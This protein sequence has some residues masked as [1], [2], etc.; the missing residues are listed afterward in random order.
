VLRS[1]LLSAQLA[2]T[3]CFIFRRGLGEEVLLEDG[4]LTLTAGCP[5][6]FPA[7]APG[8]VFARPYK[9]RSLTPG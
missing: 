5:S 1:L 2:L 7:W 8:T 6:L 4:D 9:S 3:L